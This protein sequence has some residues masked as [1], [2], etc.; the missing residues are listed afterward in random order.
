MI[1]KTFILIAIILIILSSS[2]L[3]IYHSP[4]SNIT[5]NI[6][7]FFPVT[8]KSFVRDYIFILPE[9]NMIINK[10]E[11]FSLKTI[12]EKNNIE[13]L[14][15]IEIFS[16]KI[17]NNNY[18]LTK[19][20]LPFY[21]RELSNKTVAHIDSTNQYTYIV[22]GNGNFFYFENKELFN[23]E[24][25]INKIKNNLTD[26]ISDL[27]FY[28]SSKIF[29]NSDEVSL[30]DI[31]INEDKIY[32]SYINDNEKC[33]SNAILEGNLNLKE[34]RFSKLAQLDECKKVFN[35]SMGLK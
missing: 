10:L 31:F 17:L 3:I 5:E 23:K 7:S 32:I 35:L 18:E 16:S 15:K 28:D 27:R 22:T 11:I 29:L 9:K 1:K 25:Q 24:I 19:Y 34:I 4:K 13:E 20:K 12:N 30:K 26:I 21:N 8:A 6:K 14:K 33:Y 2:L